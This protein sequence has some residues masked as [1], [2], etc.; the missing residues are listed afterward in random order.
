MPSLRECAAQ[1]ISNVTECFVMNSIVC[2]SSKRLNM[3]NSAVNIFIISLCNYIPCLPSQLMHNCCVFLLI[4]NKIDV[5]HCARIVFTEVLW[6][7]TKLIYRYPTL[8]DGGAT[9]GSD[10]E[11]GRP[12]TFYCSGKKKCKLYTAR[13]WIAAQ[14]NVM[15]VTGFV[16]LSPGWP[17]QCF[18]QLSYLP[19]PAVAGHFHAGPGWN[20]QAYNFEDRSSHSVSPLISRRIKTSVQR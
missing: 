3:D 1:R 11:S 6:W 10:E 19:T 13:K 2:L 5:L 4:W 7:H 18:N 20:K 17:T 8:N 9:T 15:A 14:L 16:P 12:S